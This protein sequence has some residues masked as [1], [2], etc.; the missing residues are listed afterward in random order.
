MS[1]KF[2][3]RGR[4]LQP[5]V[6]GAADLPAL[7]DLDEALWVA[8]AAPVKSF[9]ADPVLL[10]SL[11]TDGDGR[12]RSDELRA[13]IRW[14]LAHLSDTTGIDAKSTTV[15]VAAIPADAPDG[16]TLRTAA[17]SVAPG[18]AEVT[19]EA[20]R[21]VRADEEATGLSAAGMAALT[22]A[23]DDEALASYLGHIVEVTG[24][25]DHPV[26]GKAVTAGT[27]D[28]FLADSRAWLDW[29]DAGAT[30]AVR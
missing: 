27:L 30:D 11:D 18:A 23:G 24:G 26:G 12:I 13:A 1:M 15:R 29:S 5:V 20:I 25:V 21:K 9:R 7:L 19:L 17:E 22:A 16:P 14:T 2:A 4:G 10:A 28:Q 8:T 6:Q 3:L